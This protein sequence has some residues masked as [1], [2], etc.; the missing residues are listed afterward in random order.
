MWYQRSASVS[1][2][3]A[4][5]ATMTSSMVAQQRAAEV[6][7]QQAMH[8]EQVEGD[9]QQAIVLYQRILTAHR[10]S[11]TVAAQAQ[12]HIGL[13]YEKLG[14]TE[15][16]QAYR[17][18]IEGFPEQHDVV[19][20]AEQRLASLAQALAELRRHPTFTKIEIA[21][22]PQ[23]GVLSPGGDKLAF[24]ADS[25]LWV[26]PLRGTVGANIAGEPVRLVDVPDIWDNG[27]L[28]SWSADGK[29]I[30]V[31]SWTGDEVPVY[32]IP[33][34]GGEPRRVTM[35]DRGGHAWSYRVSLSPDGQTLAF[36]AL[37]PG[38][39]EAVQESHDRHI[40]TIPTAGGE[41]TRI[42][43]GWG[44]LPSYSPDGAR[45]S[46]VG[47]RARGDSVENSEGS[48]YDGDLWVASST[49]ANAVRLAMVAGRLRGP[50]WSPDGKYVAAHYE[51][52][53]SN[54]SRE[55]RVY[56][57]S[58]DASSAGEPT[59]ITL[60]GE[61]WHMIAGWTAHEE[62]GV[63][64][65][66]ESHQAVYT[67]PASG[68]KAVQVTPDRAW[69]WYPRWSP[70]GARIY[71]RTVQPDDVPHVTLRYVPATGGDPIAVPLDAERWLVSRVPGGGLNVSP[72]GSR[73]VM[74]AAQDPYDPKEGV[75]IWTVP[76]NGGRPTR[77]TS[78]GSFEGYPCWSPDG[79]WIAFTD[80]RTNSGSTQEQFV[81]IYMV[82]AGG[83][84]PTE[85]TSESDSVAYGPIAFSPDGQRIAFFSNG[86]IKTIASTGR[87]R[88]ALLVSGVQS[89]SQSDL[90][91]SPDGTKIAYSGAGKIWIVSLDGAAPEELRTGLPGDTQLGTF[92][93]SPDG[94][95]IA[96]VGSS[97]GDAEFWLISGFLPEKR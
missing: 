32:V 17:N 42:S 86:A 35:P 68:G 79:Q 26:V 75:D 5:A 70:D 52:G 88:P 69:T 33:A 90:F 28:M 94:K 20:T 95:R 6:A 55:I 64:L 4:C 40:Y 71:L 54:S 3:L 45:I 91:W 25:G 29:W 80:S 51:P 7:L 38:T 58:D 13:C 89:S 14:L 81:G 31:N 48:R 27:S 63:F 74:S 8:V 67:V 85:L 43:S 47:Y 18:V 37:E 39:R 56:P 83:G 96:F 36:S 78:D 22:R 76:L 16:G 21:S 12:L 46:Y 87:A 57:L 9:L 1:V 59:K 50:V 11:R 2:L 60:P 30:A 84:E 49:G 93:W 97:G 23:G 72:D 73:V 41:P 92:S 61:S 65:Q 53:T 24:I 34:S 77:L 44:R 19:A 82:P 62:L 10:E 15:A 66:S